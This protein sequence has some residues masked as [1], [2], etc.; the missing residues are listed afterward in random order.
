MKIMINVLRSEGAAFWV[1]QAMHQMLRNSVAAADIH[2]DDPALTDEMRA[3]VLKHGQQIID[4]A[5]GA[6]PASAV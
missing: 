3:Y 1:Q 4:A 6:R 5:F 2:V